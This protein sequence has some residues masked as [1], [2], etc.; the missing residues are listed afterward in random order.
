MEDEFELKPIT[1]DGVPAAIARAKHYR[2]LGQ[3][4][5]AESICLDVLDVDADSQEAV[6]VLLLAITD[7]FATQQGPGANQARELLGR[8]RDGY[9]REYY[10]GIIGERIARAALGRGHGADVAY[11]SLREAMEY[12]EKAA[13]VRPAG[14]DD[15]ILRWNA[16]VRAMRRHRL[17]PPPTPDVELGLE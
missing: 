7:Q 3:P 12:Y 6:V 5:Q 2:L 4:E 16:C 15:A 11:H 14:N 9:E 1:E 8:L 10:A 13:M 17:R